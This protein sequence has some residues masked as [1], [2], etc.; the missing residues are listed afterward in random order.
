MEQLGTRMAEREREAPTHGLCTTCIY[1]TD[2]RIHLMI[3]RSMD[4][5]WVATQLLFRFFNILFN[6]VIILVGFQ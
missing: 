6:R 4:Q 1:N 5:L 2:E 3:K